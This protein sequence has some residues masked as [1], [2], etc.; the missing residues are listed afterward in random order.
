MRHQD[1]KKIQPFARYLLSGSILA[2]GAC[3]VQPMLEADQQWL[4][5]IMQGLA[6]F[7][8]LKGMGRFCRAVRNWNL[9]LKSR[10]PTNSRGSA[11]W[12]TKENIRTSGLYNFTTQG[13]F[14]QMDENGLPLCDS[15]EKHILVE[16]PTGAGKSVRVAIPNLLHYSGSIITTDIKGELYEKTHEARQK[17][18]GNVI[19]RLDPA[20]I[21][22]NA[23]EKILR[24]NPLA[25]LVS[26]W[27]NGEETHKKLVSKTTE[28]A[29][30]LLPEPDKKDSND[31]FRGESLK[32]IE[33][34]LLYMVTHY[35]SE[36]VT[37]TELLE[38]LSSKT[39][40]EAA[41]I[42]ARCSDVLK[43]DLSRKA[44]DILNQLEE[45]NDKNYTQSI[46][47]GATRVLSFATRSGLLAESLSGHDFS[48]AVLK[49]T[50]ST[51]Y[52]IVPPDLMEAFKPWVKTVLWAML[53]GLYECRNQK[54]IL[55][56][57]DEITNFKLQSLT[58]AI[59]LARGYGARFIFIIQDL[60]EYARV[61]GEAAKDVL[62]SQT[63]IKLF[64]HVESP[65]TAEL[66]SKLC[67]DTT[68]STTSYSLGHEASDKV[69]ESTSEQ[70]RRLIT[71][72]E[73][74]RSG[75]G[76]LFVANT[77]PIKTLPLG[78]HEVMPWQK[79]QGQD[80]FNGKKYKGKIRLR[81]K[82]TTLPQR[83]ARTVFRCFT[84]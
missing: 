38:L 78:Y 12:A 82:Y 5:Y 46:R 3:K 11:Q 23:Q 43:G 7:Y 62:I 1:D 27:S 56:L 54:K 6:V 52:I 30:E 33:C 80:S 60:K 81:L 58:S 75:H 39:E 67:G 64:M 19:L 28:L 41:L 73:V 16:A 63:S 13:V 17:Y 61:Y 26:Y 76:F 25:G 50:P 77:P 21:T 14:L 68:I 55:F 47:N 79:W 51:L 59:T 37:F 34:L 45:K 35:P 20:G 24:F 53:Q 42:I 83:L 69:Q 36:R 4:F 8:G 10:K 74:L 32:W 29:N 15:S 65:E 31:H 71:V 2:Y 44:E 49:N 57:L 66:V 84:K 9:R 18:H 72:G 40:T 22:N 48:L 70:S